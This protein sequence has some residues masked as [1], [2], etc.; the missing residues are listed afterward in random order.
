M[1]GKCLLR[2]VTTSEF[3]NLTG[4]IKNFLFARIKWVTLGTHVD[5]HRL[6]C[7]SRTRYESVATATVDSDGVILWMDFWFHLVDLKIERE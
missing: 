2:A 6:T 5:I 4:S 1:L 7:V 3:I